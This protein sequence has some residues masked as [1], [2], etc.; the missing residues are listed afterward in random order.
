MTP[1]LELTLSSEVG[2]AKCS[3]AK[4]FG[5]VDQL[6]VSL[7]VEDRSD[8]PVSQSSFR[9]RL[10]TA[11][12]QPAASLTAGCDGDSFGCCLE[13]DLN[14]LDQPDFFDHQRPGASEC[15]CV[16]ERAT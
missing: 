1:A 6:A 13:N 11:R 14:V 8:G 5:R 12:G 10:K 4:R 16:R 7:S 9:C 3:Q 15:F 2:T